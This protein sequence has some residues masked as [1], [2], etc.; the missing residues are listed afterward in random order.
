MIGEALDCILAGDIVKSATILLQRFKSLET[1]SHSQNWELA[2]QLELTK[3]EKVS[4]V[5]TRE[6]D[7]AR[8]GAM[9]ERRLQLNT[10]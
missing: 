4:C 10:R 8:A 3:G 6:A 2:R 1:Y 7:C 5:S 9:Q